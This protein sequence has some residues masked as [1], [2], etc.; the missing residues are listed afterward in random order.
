[1]F[2]NREGVNIDSVTRPISKVFNYKTTVPIALG[3][4]LEPILS[5]WAP[6]LLQQ[7]S[8][9]ET[10]SKFLR[11]AA[12]HANLRRPAWIAA[13]VTLAYAFN[14]YLTRKVTNNWVEDATYDFD[15]EIVLITGGSSGIGASVAQE[16]LKR[17]RRTRLVI[18]D[19]AE[20]KWEAPAGSK[21]HFYRCDLSKSDEV[22]EMADKVRAEVGHPTVLLNNAGVA[23]AAPIIAASAEEQ[24]LVIKTNLLGQF[25]VTQQFLP[26]M[27]RRDHGHIVW[28]S[29]MSS[30][31][32]MPMVAAYSTTKAGLSALHDVC[33]FIMPLLRHIILTTCV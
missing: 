28:S 25:F 8:Q 5:R 4:S 31:F 26:E 20:M 15:R 3:L 23:R 13:A 22:K 9:N 32:P 30:V 2:S 33:L 7:L 11:F 17:N 24:E 1:M 27:I 18:V 19:F 16:F 10:A 21:V 12:E 29:S 6:S 14:S